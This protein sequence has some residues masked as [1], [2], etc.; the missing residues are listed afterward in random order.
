M[1]GNALYD[2]LLLALPAGA[3]GFW[4][5]GARAREL[6]IEHARNACRAQHVQ[7][8]DQSV[9]LQRVRPSRAPGGSASL[10]REF[11]FEFTDA[12]EYRDRATVLM[13]GR[14]LVRVNFPYRRDEAGNRVFEQ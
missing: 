9:A 14:H 2:L 1:T 8:L 6:A 7:F 5:T 13:N 10:K 3:I 12:G 4:W 11:A